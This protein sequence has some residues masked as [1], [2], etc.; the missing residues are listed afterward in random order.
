M[1]AVAESVGRWVI[2]GT[3]GTGRQ[4]CLSLKPLPG[5]FDHRTGSNSSSKRWV[6][7]VWRPVHRY[8]HRPVYGRSLCAPRCCRLSPVQCREPG[9]PTVGLSLAR[10]LAQ[11]S[12]PHD[13]GRAGSGI[14][15]E[16]GDA[17]HRQI[18][19]Y[20]LWRSIPCSTWSS[21]ASSLA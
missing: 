16:L 20:T 6:G 13:A 9:G 2:S 4:H 21:P 1:K 15:T 18:V 7:R 11:Y 3:E 12:R 5:Y 8:A 17:G 10:E 19:L 14:A